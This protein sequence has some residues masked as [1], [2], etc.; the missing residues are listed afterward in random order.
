VQVR[1]VSDERVLLY[2]KV[3]R[4]YDPNF[5]DG[6]RR[7]SFDGNRSHEINSRLI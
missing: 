1:P 5:P 2:V 7:I 6:G 3:A 4:R